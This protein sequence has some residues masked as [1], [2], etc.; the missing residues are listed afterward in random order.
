MPS[1]IGEINAKIQ[2]NPDNAGLYNELGDTHYDRSEFA[3]AIECYKKAIERDA[4]VAQY[5]NNL[6]YT[7]YMVGML[8]EAIAAYHEAIRLDPS[9]GLYHNN[10]S[11]ALA[12]K[13][14]QPFK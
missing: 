9:N 8:D 2:E 1:R 6:G 4:T 5:H 14:G 3:A 7:C 11:A 12:M 10:I 13:A